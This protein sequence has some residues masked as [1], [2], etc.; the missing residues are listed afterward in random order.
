M[1]KEIEEM[2]QNIQHDRKLLASRIAE[3]IE[4]RSMFAQLKQQPTKLMRKKQELFEEAEQVEEKIKQLDEN[5]KVTNQ[6][7]ESE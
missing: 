1:T 5:L 7:L 3:M 2:E 4:S 6:Y